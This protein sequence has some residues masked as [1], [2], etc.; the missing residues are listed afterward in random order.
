MSHSQD[1]Y[2]S[3]IKSRKRRCRKRKRNVHLAAVVLITSICIFTAVFAVQTVYSLIELKDAQQNSILSNKDSFYNSLSDTNNKNQSEIDEDIFENETETSSAEDD[4]YSCIVPVSEPVGNEY[5]DDVVFIGDSRTEGMI[6]NTG[7]SNAFA[8]TDKG[9]MVDT[10]FTKPAVNMDG[11][12]ISVMDALKR[13]SFGKVYIMLGINETGWPYS[14][15]FI[16]RYGAIIDEIRS[17]NPNALIYIQEIIPVTNQVSQTHDYVKNE[18]IKQ[19]NTLLQQL[20][21]DKQVYYIDVGTALVSEDG[22]LPQDA[23]TDGIHLNKD[24]CQLWLDYLKTHTVC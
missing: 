19:Y 15:V 4:N 23:A 13:T 17:I 7:L 3:D 1:N 5:F 22:S 9:L 2:S 20:A 14:E 8:Y 21:Q 16:E 6:F 24:Y 18:K 10:A 12:K 11:E